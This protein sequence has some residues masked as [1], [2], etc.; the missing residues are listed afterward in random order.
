MW[1]EKWCTYDKTA[2]EPPEHKILSYSEADHSSSS[3]AEVKNAWS[4]TTTPSQVPVPS[5]VG[6]TYVPFLT[7]RELRI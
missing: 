6:W 3:S 2:K 1:G 5:C 4:F 7:Y